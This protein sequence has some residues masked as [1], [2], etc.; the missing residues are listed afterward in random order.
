MVMLSSV[1]AEVDFIEE[2]RL[3]RW[4]RENYVPR[5][6]R[7]LAWHPVILDEMTR[8]DNEEAEVETATYTRA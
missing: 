3:R 7:Q 2:L 5:T 6:Q 8:K 1:A 4:A